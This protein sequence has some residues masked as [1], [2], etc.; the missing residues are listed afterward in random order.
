[1]EESEKMNIL[2]LGASGAGKST[3]IKAI[4]GT[5][6][7]T[8]VGEGNTQKIDVYESTTW[9]I[10]SIDTKGFEY[11]IFEQWKTIHQVKKYTKE[12]ISN[13]ENSSE[14]GIDAIWY[15]I[16]GTARRTFSHNINLMNKAIKGWKNIPVFAV[17][18]KSY[19]EVDIPENI[20]AVKQA[21]AKSK[22]INLKKII[23]VVAEEYVINE[24]ITVAPKGIEELCIQTLDC[25]D[26]A[27]KINK[28]NRD[29]MIL[30]QKRFTANGAVVGATTS[31]VVIGAVPIPF[32]DSI[33][34]MP[35]ET[36]LTKL[37]FK[38]YKVNYSVE[39]VTAIVG[40]T[41]I[42]TVAKSILKAIP[43]AGAVAN[44]V[45]AGAIVFAL[46]QS[47]IAASE[48]IYNGKLEPTKINEMVE[49]VGEKV[50]EN[51][52][53]G[54]TISY[55]EQNK[56]KIQDKKPKEILDEIMKSIKS[57]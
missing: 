29:R 56:D 55:F 12:Q 47:V 14:I 43:I 16:E 48:A 19:S 49:F 22:N 9:P 3:L 24:E 41:M 28:T 7:I 6:V 18:T 31:A 37:I 34:L 35:L 30:E 15:C 39:L 1:M 42:T 46:G 54:A 13:K 50:K 32:P 52:I 27:K 36:G 20:E 57:K 51:A 44:G 10:R 17:I 40:S 2:V 33:I 26:E 38:I 5:E 21:F 8:G 53:V 25:L 45:V 4:S 11:N 23:P